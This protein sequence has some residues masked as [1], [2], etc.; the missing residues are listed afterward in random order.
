MPLFERNAAI[1]MQALND[2]AKMVQSAAEPLAE[3]LIRFV[4]V[5]HNYCYPHTSCDSLLPFAIS[6][7]HHFAE[8]TLH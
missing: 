2:T 3:E 8:L 4:A 5:K 7:C 6:L 1:F